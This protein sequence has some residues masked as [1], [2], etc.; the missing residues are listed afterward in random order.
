MK[1]T[2]ERHKELMNDPESSLT[3]DEIEEGYVFCCNWDGAL[4][5]KDDIEA[6]A[7]VCLLETR[8]EV[9]E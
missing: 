7:C 2:H 6:A 3:D 1:M 4:I 9:I 8:T 5:H